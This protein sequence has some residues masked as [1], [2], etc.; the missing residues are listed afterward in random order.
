M[1][2][3]GLQ[4]E[5]ADRR[6]ERDTTS[7]SV[8]SGEEEMGKMTMSSNGQTVQEQKSHRSPKSG[9]RQCVFLQNRRMMIHFYLI[10]YASHV[11][12]KKKL[13]RK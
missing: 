7:V 5:R 9:A 8:M 11:G 4:R 10:S 13:V 3:W 2:A 6:L 1:R 12:L